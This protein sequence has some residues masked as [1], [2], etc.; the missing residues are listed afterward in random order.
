MALNY[1]KHHSRNDPNSVKAV[2]YILGLVNSVLILND[3]VDIS[4][5]EFWQP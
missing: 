4:L 3:A 1:L 5:V 2:V